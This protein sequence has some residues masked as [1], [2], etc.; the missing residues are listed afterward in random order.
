MKLKYGMFYYFLI[1]T[2]LLLLV[3]FSKNGDISS[4][5]FANA[6][7]FYAILYHPL[8]SGIRL[9]RLGIISK[10]DILKSLIPF[11]NLRYAKDLFAL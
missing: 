5:F 6:I 8:V 1:L 4:T 2:P 11:W 9:F 3:L 10:K 7:L